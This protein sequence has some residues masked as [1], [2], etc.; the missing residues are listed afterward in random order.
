MISLMFGFLLAFAIIVFMAN[1]VFFILQKNNSMYQTNADI[2]R[3]M[4]VLSDTEDSLESY[5]RNRTF[6]SINK[7]YQNQNE[8]ELS[9]SHLCSYPSSDEILH[10]E[11]IIRQLSF[12]FFDLS[13]K[14]VAARRANN[15]LMADIYFSK[16]VDCYSLLR[17]KI[18]D[19]NMYFF[20]QNAINYSRN[21]RLSTILIKQII[22]LVFIVLIASIIL[23]FM[24]VSHTVKPLSDISEVALKLAQRDFDVELFNNI[25]KNEIGNIC[26]A[27]DSMVI[28]IREYIKTIWEKAL[29]ENELREREIEVK[30]LYTESQLKTLQNQVKPH[31]LFNTLNTGAQLAMIE[32]ADKTC[33]FLEQVA[34][35]LRYNIQHPENEVTIAQELAMLDSYIYIMKVRFGERYSFIKDVD[36][37]VIDV[38]MPDMILQPLVEN[39]IKHGLA[40]VIENGRIKITVKGDKEYIEISITDNGCG[41][42]PH[43][44]E[45]LFNQ[46]NQNSHFVNGDNQTGHV[47]MGLVNVISRLRL[48]F[49][50]KDVLSIMQNPEG[51]GTMFYIKIKRK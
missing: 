25:K 19:L 44:K 17:E 20:I 26:R 37:S 45:V 28:S 43:V 29:K 4:S 7:F 1:I 10:W 47:S 6:E 8:A 27:F 49:D 35:F 48:Y 42:N 40:D 16:S 33:Y 11:F 31:F 2:N 30:A 18:M 41:F 38:K 21:Q 46:C 24:N 13:K 14:A 5:M 9:A 51:Q 12:S 39:C 36:E 23:I 50:D 22:A 32:G 3:Y 34:D 15:A